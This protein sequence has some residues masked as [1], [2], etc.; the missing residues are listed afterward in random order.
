MITLYNIKLLVEW[1]W[2]FFIILFISIP[3][4]FLFDLPYQKDQSFNLCHGNVIHTGNGVNLPKQLCQITLKIASIR[5]DL[6][7]NDILLVF[8]V[9]ETSLEV[10]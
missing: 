10:K 8:L 7:L 2:C 9:Q 1:G 3:L 5:A 6:M 4:F